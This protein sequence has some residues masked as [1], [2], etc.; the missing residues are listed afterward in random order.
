MQFEFPYSMSKDEA[1]KRL[2]ALCDYLG[3]RHGLR[4]EWTGDVASIK[5]RYTVVKIDGSMR[6]NDGSVEFTGK[7]PGMLWRKKAVSYLRG[8]L[9]KYLDPSVPVAEL[10]RS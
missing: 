1:R 10:P 3:N 6:L 5:G 9:G 4:P 7:D 2:E 8:K